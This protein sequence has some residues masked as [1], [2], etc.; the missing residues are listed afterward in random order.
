MSVSTYWWSQAA[1]FLLLV[2]LLQRLLPGIRGLLL[3]SLVAVALCVVPFFGHELRYWLSGLTPNVSIP[4]LVL[5]F[6]GILQRSGL[7]ALFRP[8]E[9]SSA[10]IFG[11]VAAL[12]L[13]PSALGL[14][15][16]NYD[17]YSLGWP[18]LDW[19]ASFVLF[20]PVALA[21]AILIC[22]GNRFGWVLVLGA[23][24]FLARAQESSNFWDYLL[25][26][27]Y[28]AV[29]LCLVVRSILHRRRATGVA[30]LQQ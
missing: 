30:R 12:L 27:V 20:A 2:W 14:G 5:L 23:L 7:A 11:T 3:S 21:A 22:F 10:W 19:T 13:Y 15:L 8:R 26:P 17:S 4:L 29:A 24:S 18:W 9:W 16:R 25:D 1:V 28:G 6:I